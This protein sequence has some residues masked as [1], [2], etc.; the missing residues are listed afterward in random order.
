VD[1]IMNNGVPY[2]GATAFLDNQHV[3]NDFAADILTGGQGRDW[4]FRDPAKTG[5]DSITDLVDRGPGKETVVV[6][7]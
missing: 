6:T 7:K 3:H 1:N 4:F 5:I 2:A